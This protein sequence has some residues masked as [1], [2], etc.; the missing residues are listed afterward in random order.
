MVGM[1]SVEGMDD[2]ERLSQAN[3]TTST[4]LGVIVL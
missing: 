3:Q 1:G 4:T 2:V